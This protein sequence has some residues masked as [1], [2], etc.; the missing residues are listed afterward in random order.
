MSEEHAADPTPEPAPAAVAPEPA[1]APAETPP[2]ATE[3]GSA[4]S[5]AAETTA[6]PAVAA[7]PAI[8]PH[9][10]EPGLLQATPEPPAEEAKL[11]DGE[12]PAAPEAETVVYDFGI[13]DGFT[14][15]DGRMTELTAVMQEAH[16][17]KEHAEKLWAMHTDAMREL[18][19]QNVQ[20]QHDSWA[21]MRRGWR[22]QIFSDP[23]LGAAGYDTNKAA[24]NRMLDL[25][26]PPEHRK[27]LN[28]FLST[29]GA[30]DH[31]AL[32][33]FLLNI[34]K[35]FDEPQGGPPPNPAPLP[36]RDAMGQ[37]PRGG[38]AGAL[39]GN[40]QRRINYDHPRGGSQ[41]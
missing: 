18:A 13:P 2:Q 33:R 7:E 36:P 4:E 11:P 23:E 8:K 22:N 35:G 29:T 10:D 15:P 30:T 26:T 3:Q 34:A 37:R 31:P 1:A 17:S 21:E 32:F 24:A 38:S 25:F 20:A 14:V 39:S 27:A 5:A 19:T 12:Q 6:E 9:T 28:E 40:G 41:T 16:V